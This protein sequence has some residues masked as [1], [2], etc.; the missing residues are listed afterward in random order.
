M[1]PNVSAE[2]HVSINLYEDKIAPV[3]TNR[4]YNNEELENQQSDEIIPPLS[5]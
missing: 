1:N 4:L 5:I 2:D 3:L